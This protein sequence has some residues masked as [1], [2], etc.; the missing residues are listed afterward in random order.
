MTL[1]EVREGLPFQLISRHV[2]SHQDDECVFDDLTRPEQLNAL[3][4]HRATAAL[5][6]LRAAG[7][8]TEFYPLPACR[9]YLRD[10]TGYITGREIRTLG[11]ELTEYELRDY[12][13]KRNEWSDEVDDSISWTAYR[14]ASAGLTDSLRTFVVKL[15]HG[16]LPIGVRERRCRGTTD[17]CPQYNEIETVPHLYRC[18]V[19]GPWRHRFLIHLHARLT[20]TKTAADIRCIIIKGIESWFLTGDTN[21]PDSVETVAQI[22]W[23]QVL[24]GYIPNDWTSR[25][26][27]FYRRQRK[28]YFQA[29]GGRK[30]LSSSSKTLWKDRCKVAHTPGEDSPDNSSARS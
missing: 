7:Q 8:T 18:H 12:L 30:T 9:G 3:A 4:D 15:S 6:A 14:S 16:W 25:Q 2:K 27:T 24:K 11:T 17:L 20:E 29:S 26:E 19:R 23:F 5:D 10:G 22:G 28:K 13:Q 21:D 1:S